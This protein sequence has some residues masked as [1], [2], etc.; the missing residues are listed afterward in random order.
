MATARSVS[1]AELLAEVSRTA[2]RAGTPLVVHLVANGVR[3][4]SRVIKSAQTSAEQGF[5]TIVLGITTEDEPEALDLDGVIG[6]LLPYAA[7]VSLPAIAEWGG[8]VG[9]I[10]AFRA[11]RRA[12]VVASPRRRFPGPVITELANPVWAVGRPDYLGANVAFAAALDALRPAAIHVH[13]TVPLPAGIAHVSSRRLRGKSVRVM[14]DSHECVPEL[15][16]SFPDSP[17]FRA[18]L[19]IE[20]NYIR[21]ADRVITVSRQIANVLQD[22]YGLPAKPG[23][24]VNAPSATRDFSAPDLRDVIGLQADVPLAVYSGWLAGERGL[25]TVVRAMPSLPL[26]H[27]AVVCNTA[28]RT[29]VD[30]VR[31]ARLLGVADRVHFAGYVA[32]SQVTQYLSSAT[33]G[34]IPRKSGGHLDLSL[35]TKYREFLHAG[36]PLV[37]SNNKAMA[38][39]IRATAVGEVFRAGSV[40]G[41]VESL[42]RVLADPERYR[43]AITPELLEAHSWE[44]QQPILRECYLKLSKEAPRSNGLADIG[45]VFR[46]WPGLRFSEGAHAVT[47]ISDPR[48]TATHVGIGRAN[49][50]GQA[51][52]WAAALSRG[53]GVTAESFAPEREMCHRPHRVVASG[54]QDLQ[55]MAGELGRILGAYTHLLVD[56][57]ECLAGGLLGDDIEPELRVLERH[58]VRVGLIAHGSDVRDPAAHMARFDDSYFR[59]VPA[60]WLDLVG[61]RAARNREI[62]CACNGAVFVSTPDLLVDLPQATWLPVVVDLDPWAGIP[63]LEER[64][65]PRVLHRPSRST[66]PIKGSDAIVPVLEELHRRGIIEYLPDAGQVPADQMPAL[67]QQADIVVDQIRTGSYGVAAV[68]AMAGGRVV[69]GDLAADVRAFVRDDIPIVDANASDLETVL[70]RLAAN[71][72]ILLKLG[73]AGRTFAATWHSGEASA[74]ALV[75]FLTS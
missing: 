25:G 40:S 2:G 29:V 13:D 32:P 14:Y 30:L 42:E 55:R 65:V 22:T 7:E 17:V 35:P 70:T 11:L 54:P 37:T 28:N 69:V 61:G 20:Q 23:I 62:A 46:R 9:Q 71:P 34:L 26:L 48:F 4:D 49:S 19:A 36:L 12:R 16:R 52:Q 21:D 50:A 74:R 6:V 44:S 5:A 47:R 31:Q 53:F 10:R 51:Y 75:P 41:L 39:E 64:T 66:P 18:I 68:E 38:R 15:A 1:S 63:D 60:E 3:G 58:A 67:V 33:V 73:A 45:G 27:L 43:R 57:F 72:A 24:V 59:H 8:R 56:G